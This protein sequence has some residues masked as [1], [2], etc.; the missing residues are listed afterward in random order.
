MQVKKPTPKSTAKRPAATAK[1]RAK[2]TP[3]ATRNRAVRWRFLC[4]AVQVSIE[5]CW[6][7]Q[8]FAAL[9]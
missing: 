8:L 5:A 2:Q 1:T 3:Q 4:F 7:V 6:A 9:I